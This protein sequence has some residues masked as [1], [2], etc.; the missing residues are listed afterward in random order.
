M[1]V[2]TEELV[3]PF[4]LI[5][6]YFYFFLS[7]RRRFEVLKVGVENASDFESLFEL[8]KR[9]NSL[10]Q[11]RKIKA[12]HGLILRNTI[13]EKENSIRVEDA[14]EAPALERKADGVSSEEA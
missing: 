3:I 1:E 2:V 12:L 14:N 13:E 5:P 8:E 4:L 10:I 11:G 9:V 7:R 6:I